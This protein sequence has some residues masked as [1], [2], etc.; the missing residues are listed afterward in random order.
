MNWSDRST[1]ILIS[2]HPSIHQTLQQTSYQLDVAQFGCEWVCG[3][4]AAT[5]P[6]RLRPTTQQT[7]YKLR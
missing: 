6:F 2:I 1:G 7:S 3:G 5:H 4:C